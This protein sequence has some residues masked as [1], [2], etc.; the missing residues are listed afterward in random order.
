MSMPDSPPSKGSM[1][2]VNQPSA[3]STDFN[4]NSSSQPVEERLSAEEI[5]SRMAELRTAAKEQENTQGLLEVRLSFCFTAS[6]VLD[7]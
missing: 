7:V 2:P 6:N 1:G 3:G 5:A 4:S